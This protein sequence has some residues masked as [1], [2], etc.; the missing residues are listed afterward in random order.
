LL[1]ILTKDLS[2]FYPTPDIIDIQ[3]IDSDSLF[4]FVENEKSGIK[5]ELA[6]SY[7]RVMQMVRRFFPMP[8]PGF[9]DFTETTL[10]QWCCAMLSHSIASKTVRKYLE[11]LSAIHTKAVRKGLTIKTDAF[12]EV[13]AI[14]H[15]KWIDHCSIATEESVERLAD[16][17]RKRDSIRGD[18][19]LNVDM[20]LFS[21]FNKGL[22]TTTLLSVTSD[23][24]EGMPDEALAIARRHNS[25]RRKKVFPRIQVDVAE[26]RIKMALLHFGLKFP[27][28]TDVQ[29]AA[30]ALWIA[31]A[32][33]SGVPPEAIRASLHT[34]DISFAITELA[35][36][37][38]LTDEEKKE[39]EKQVVGHLVD[40]PSNWHVLKLRH[41]T[42]YPALKER[43]RRET[44]TEPEFYYPQ[45]VIT[46]RIGH[47]LEFKS[48][49]IIPEL[50]FLK[51][52]WNELQH[53]I[54]CTGDLAW[55]YRNTRHGSYAVVPAEEMASFQQTIGIFTKDFDIE[56]LGTNKACIGHRARILG[57]EMAG[58]EGV[59]YD[60]VGQ[61]NPA[62]TKLFR[63][64]LPG[65]NG[66]E[67]KV[68]ID[69]R[70]IEWL[71]GSLNA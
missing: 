2:G 42:T 61:D 43:I 14:F 70:R 47:K 50:V 4:S 18:L 49:P 51:C 69:E 5:D 41:N 3:H 40:S 30:R 54:G 68:D 36:K 21:F 11:T 20:F 6:Y 16:L 59:I 31:A 39:I 71:G 13:K 66:I 38:V 60:I 32:L 64:K 55:C 57:G 44:G 12:R 58:Y 17:I 28:G 35:C 65:N 45:E 26:R 67:W 63:L 34:S 22:S 27:E 15:M 1:D 37:E 62:T 23:S 53:A 33:R 7:D 10:R 56:P 52:T 48:K 29:Q 8:S 19:R 25:P 46:Q 24:L 9:N